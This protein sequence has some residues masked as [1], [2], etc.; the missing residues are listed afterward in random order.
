MYVDTFLTAYPNA[1]VLLNIERPSDHPKMAMVDIIQL[2]E[3][4]RKSSRGFECSYGR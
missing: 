1:N 3:I 2:I 4:S